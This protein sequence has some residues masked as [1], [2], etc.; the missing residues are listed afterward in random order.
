MC[1]API[2]DD[3]TLEA[4]ILLQSLVEE[5]VVLAGVIAVHRL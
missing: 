1:G 2:G 5:I 3:E 4:E